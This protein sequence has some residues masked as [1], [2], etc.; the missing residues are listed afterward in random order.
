MYSNGPYFKYKDCET[1]DTTN[2]V[3]ITILYLALP[4]LTLVVKIIIASYKKDLKFSVKI[5]R[6][7]LLLFMK[8]SIRS[9]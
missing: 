6:C 9:H 3:V 1:F 8:E 4:R 2:P 7:C 5:P